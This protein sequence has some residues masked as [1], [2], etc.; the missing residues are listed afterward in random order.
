MS[1]DP[2]TPIA[3]DEITQADVP[4]STEVARFETANAAV[5]AAAD[6]AAALPGVPGR[7]EFLALAMQARM[8]S[9]SGAAPEAVRNNPYIAFH[10]AMVGRDLGISPSA[11]IEL[12]DV[13]NTSKGPRL[14]LS[15]QLI[16]GQIRRL[17]LGA[18][19]PGERTRERAVAVVFDAEGHQ[20]GE[21]EFTWEDAIDAGLVAAGCR[22]GEHTE[23][24][25]NRN[26]PP[27]NRCNQGYVTYPKRM[28]WWRAAGFA[29]DDY[30]PEAGLGLYSPEALG[31][32]VDED[33]RPIDPADVELPAGYETTDERAAPR[34]DEAA[35]PADRWD[36]Q[37]RIAALPDEYKG[38]LRE[39]WL[40]AQLL[41]TR[42]LP[43]DQLRKAKALVNGFEAK[44]KR[45]GVDLDT[46]RSLIEAEVAEGFTEFLARPDGAAD[47][48]PDG[49]SG[50]VPTAQPSEVPTP[51]AEAETATQRPVETP[52]ERARRKAAAKDQKR[53][54]GELAQHVAGL[55]A[56]LGSEVSAP[57]VAEVD[58]LGI[59]ELN[60]RLREDAQVSA[61]EMKLPAEHRRLLLVQYLYKVAR[62]GNPL[63]PRDDE[64]PF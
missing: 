16:N 15:P 37:V 45:D 55:G 7:D 56:Q 19:Q 64:R 13:I 35:D 12:I 28:L 34:V 51:P 11:A 44:A 62:S 61:D 49:P 3:P 60:R 18:I 27:Y 47:V 20:L 52:K 23:R 36:L 4:P 59:A 2:D 31:A 24:C 9:L 57:I 14:S 63:E 1:D 48:P 25:R 39:N 40:R 17:G 21:V 58:G 30:F 26:T 41:P 42:T 33:G 54:T 22:P 6:A 5:A 8:L 46:Q 10:V 50:P 32:V 29:A 43:A 38:E 53:R